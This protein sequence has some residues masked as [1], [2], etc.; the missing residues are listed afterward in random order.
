MK[1]LGYDCRLPSR[2]TATTSIDPTIA[3]I[4]VFQFFSRDPELA[5]IPPSSLLCRVASCGW[6]VDLKPRHIADIVGFGT[7]RIPVARYFLG[8]VEA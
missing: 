4:K 2:Y 6:L 7:N 5:Q 3:R 8:I 1:L